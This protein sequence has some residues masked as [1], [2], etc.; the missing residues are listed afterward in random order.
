M[1]ND[2]AFNITARDQFS[3]VFQRLNSRAAAA[4]RPMSNVQRQAQGIFRASGVSELGKGF[5]VVS[6]H[7]RDIAGHLGSM[8]GPAGG[9]FG[10]AAA[11]SIAGL[12]AAVTALTA[13]WA[14]LGFQVNRTSMMIG[15]STDDLQKW[16][17]IAKL[18]G[19]SA[20]DATQALSKLAS[21]LH[22]A[23]YGDMQARAFVVKLEAM[24]VV[25]KRN[26]DGTYDLNDALMQMSR[27]FKDVIG[28]P[29]TR[30]RMAEGLGLE[31]LL[32]ALV[33]GQDKLRAM[34][35]EVQRLDMVQGA[36]ALKWAEDFTNSL[37][38]MKGALE[39]VF[40]RVGQFAAPEMTKA[41]NAVAAWIAK[42]PS[43]TIPPP[44]AFTRFPGSVKSKEHGATGGWDSPR[45]A[46]ATGGWDDD[47]RRSPAPPSSGAPDD[48]L[49][50][51]LGWNANAN[52]STNPRGTTS[53]PAQ[54]VDLTVTIKGLPPGVSASAAVNGRQ[55]PARIGSAL[56]AGNLP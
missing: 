53:G 41:M 42:P 19:L 5:A 13:K 4:V 8:S 52:R 50:A 26:A 10:L 44:V 54:P 28:N 49:R 45:G 39:G 9:L 3:T 18:A 15:V 38:R 48:A 29:Q 11:G 1:A 12:I 37:N 2:F 31:A 16:Q 30:M 36:G 24:G 35:D 22:A 34:G 47:G 17:G 56:P 55:V 14:G 33:L 51:A 46:G 25:L 23:N 21:T 32:P 20:G 7:T 27:I 43:E 6:R 40:N